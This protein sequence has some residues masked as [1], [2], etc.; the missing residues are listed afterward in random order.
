L[1]LRDLLE[2]VL[3]ASIGGRCSSV[4]DATAQ[5]ADSCGDRARNKVQPDSTAYFNRHAEAKL[6]LIAHQ[7]Y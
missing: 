6:S 7:M 4:A 3:S 1:T 2:Q 5:I